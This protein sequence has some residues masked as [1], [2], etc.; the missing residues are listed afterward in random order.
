MRIAI[1]VDD[2]ISNTAEVD[3]V[4]CWE[5]NKRINPNDKKKYVS[6]YHN[7]PTIF[8]F[9]KQQD[10]E[11][12]IYQRKLCIEQDLIK[13]KIFADKIIGKLL[14]DGNEII[15]LTS[16]GDK[17]WGDALSETKKWLDRYGIK[18]TQCVANSGNK[19]E[20]CKKNK[21]DLM[22]DDNLKYIKQCNDMGIMTITFDNNYD[23]SY[24]P[25]ELKNFESPLNQFASCWSEA[26]EIIN[27]L[28]KQSI[29]E[30]END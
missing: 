15:I 7:A 1:D 3:F 16:R 18:Y 10:D 2:C 9:T 22:I 19:G 27:D 20:F 4:T 21:I 26:Y 6:G 17:Y 23:Q 13:P 30:Q 24:Y 14:S 29:G 8:G 28:S 11:F 5:Y 25:E 12:Y